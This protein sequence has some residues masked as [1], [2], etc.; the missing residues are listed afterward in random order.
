MKM[1]LIED[2][3]AIAR[4]LLLRWQEAAWIVRH[5]ADLSAASTAMQQDTFDVAVLDLGLPDGDGLEW[6]K[7][8]RERN[9]P[10]QA[11]ILSARGHVSERVRGLKV[12]DDYVTKPFAPEELDARIERLVRRAHNAKAS[13]IGIGPLS[14]VLDEQLAFLDG[15]RLELPTREY[16]VLQMLARRSPGIV[17]KSDILQALALAKPD[18]SDSAVELY[19]SRLRKQLKVSSIVITTVVGVGYQLRDGASG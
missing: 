5:A 10:L 2:D 19:I 15:V 14:L 17:L 1:L 8:L 12:A 18:I 6:L 3:R 16:E 7:E 4:E 9:V 13:T 11:I